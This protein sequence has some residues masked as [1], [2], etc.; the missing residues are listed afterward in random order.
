MHF[1]W[2]TFF[3]RCWSGYYASRDNLHNLW[4][5]NAHPDPNDEWDRLGI[6]LS[7]FQCLGQ[8]IHGQ[9]ASKVPAKIPDDTLSAGEVQDH[10]QVDILMLQL[11]VRDIRCPTWFNPVIFALFWRFGNTGSPWMESVVAGLNSFFRQRRLSLRI[12]L[13]TRLWLAA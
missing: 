1:V 6:L 12:S 5:H 4:M 3:W 13:G 7:D 8:G 10:C 2:I 9:L 11:E